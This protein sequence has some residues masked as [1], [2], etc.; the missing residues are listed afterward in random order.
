MI[1]GVLGLDNGGC[2]C[3][4]HLP[5]CRARPHTANMSAGGGERRPDD[6]GSHLAV[7][8]DA[9]G[10]ELDVRAWRREQAAAARRARLG[11]LVYTRRWHRYGLSG[12]LVAGI[13]LMVAVFGSLLALLVPSGGRE[14]VARR[15]LDGAPPSPVGS[16]GGLLVDRRL[17]VHGGEQP[18]RELRPAVLA[19]LPTPC[20]CGELIDE[21]SGQAAEFGVRVVLVAPGRANDELSRLVKA[22]RH[23]PVLPAYDPEGALARAYAASG[24]TLVLVRD[25]G[26][27][28]GVERQ[29]RAGLRREPALRPLVRAG[30]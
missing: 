14:R 9:R 19:L 8:D 18:V 10:L 4:S 7:P 3:I 21:L 13:L 30:D 5:N 15:P 27:V 16:V 6:D 25:D 1:A 29:A 22:A 12:P 2:Q 20:G 26:R 24:P 23:G 28:T 17:Q 11:R